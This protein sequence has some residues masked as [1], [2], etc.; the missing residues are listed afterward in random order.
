MRNRPVLRKA[1]VAGDG[2][3]NKRIGLNGGM[4]I[5][6]HTHAG[7]PRR[8]GDVDRAV[9]AIMRPPGVAACVV[10]AS[11]GIPMIRRDRDTNRLEKFRDPETG[12]CLRAVE[13]YFGSFEQGGLRIARE[14]DD[15]RTEMPDF[16]RHPEIVMALR[17]RGLH[18]QEV[19]KVCS[20]NWLRV[21]RSVRA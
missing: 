7:R 12:E 19:E 9:L 4:I 8:T 17:D 13:G 18:Q 11:G 2:D 5:D 16:S 21:L 3:G 15:V 10:S 14:P 1:N 20:G 6:M